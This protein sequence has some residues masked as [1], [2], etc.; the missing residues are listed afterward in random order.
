MNLRSRD[1]AATVAA[2]SRR[3]RLDTR[4]VLSLV[5]KGAQRPDD[6]L[7]ELERG[8][9]P[10][11]WLVQEAEGRER[12]RF[13]V[14]AEAAEHRDDPDLAGGWPV[15]QAATAESIA[16]AGCWHPTRFASPS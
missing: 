16:L 11:D 4:G 2:A 14:L 10:G 5:F 3:I 12:R 9:G 13:V 7:I 6:D 15:R 1:T 8:L